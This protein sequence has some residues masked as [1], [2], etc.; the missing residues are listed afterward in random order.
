MPIG[1]LGPFDD[2]GLRGPIFNLTYK[3][4]SEVSC[5]NKTVPADT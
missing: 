2:D 3:N 5:T 1:Y 4:T